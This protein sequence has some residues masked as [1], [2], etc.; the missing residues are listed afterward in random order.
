MEK[1]NVHRCLF[2]IDRADNLASKLVI[3]NVGLT[4]T[5]TKHYRKVSLFF[6]VCTANILLFFFYK[7][8]KTMVKG[9]QEEIYILSFDLLYDGGHHPCLCTSAKNNFKENQR[10]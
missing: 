3:V 7:I 1:G 4:L 5:D 8:S 9:V 6:P 2:L 10:K